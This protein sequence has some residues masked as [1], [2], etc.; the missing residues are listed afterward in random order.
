M[1]LVSVFS[2]TLFSGK[3]T[4]TFCTLFTSNHPD[5]TEEENFQKI[6]IC[7]FIR[8]IQGSCIQ[9]AYQVFHVASH[10]TV[11]RADHLS[12]RSGHLGQMVGSMDLTS[13][14]TV[15]QSYKGDGQA[16]TKG[17]KQ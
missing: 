11:V 2:F 12:T 7:P 4:F 14:S 13:F 16:I 9:F 17:C 1:Y 6:T 8:H 10:E 5:V 15:F 3:Y